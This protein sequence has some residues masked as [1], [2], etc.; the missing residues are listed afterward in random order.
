MI[1]HGLGAGGGYTCGRVRVNETLETES[2]CRK[3]IVAMF[4]AVLYESLVCWQCALVSGGHGGVDHERG[5][6]RL[7]L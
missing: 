7:C 5:S 2:G 3:V 6:R 1:R 4:I